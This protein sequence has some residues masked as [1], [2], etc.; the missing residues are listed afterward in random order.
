MALQ[1]QMTFVN[2]FGEDSIFDETY[3]KVEEV[4]F[5]KPKAESRVSYRKNKED[6]ILKEDYF[7]FDANVEVDS[8]NAIAQAYEYLKTLPEF[9]DATDV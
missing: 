6:K 4:I 1:K 8:K 7:E 5:S 3:I 9:A 2:N